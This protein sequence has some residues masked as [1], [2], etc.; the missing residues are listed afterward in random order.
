MTPILF[1]LSTTGL[2]WQ[3]REKRSGVCKKIVYC[4]NAPRRYE[5][6]PTSVHATELGNSQSRD[7]PIAVFYRFVTLKEESKSLRRRIVTF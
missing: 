4:E 1:S 7:F 6:I 5:S 3:G 2:V